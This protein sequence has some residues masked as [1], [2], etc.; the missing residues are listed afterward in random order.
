VT[1]S[2]PL[3]TR[4]LVAGI[5][6]IVVL[7]GFLLMLLVMSF[8]IW[9]FITAMLGLGVGKACTWMIS[10]PNLE[11]IGSLSNGSVLYEAKA[12]QC[13]GDCH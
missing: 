9:V 10:R 12:D 8:N 3:G 6:L 13:C 1:I 11:K 2:I 4:L 7:T 5:Q